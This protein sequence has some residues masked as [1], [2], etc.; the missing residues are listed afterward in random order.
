MGVTNALG[1]MS[2][3]SYV[4]TLKQSPVASQ[5]LGDN[6]NDANTLLTLN[7]PDTR[8]KI[9]DGFTASLT[10]VKAPTAVKDKLKEDF[11]TRQDKYS[12]KIVNA[13]S[14]S[15][16]HIFLVS[17]S[18]MVVALILSTMITERELRSASPDETPGE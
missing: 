18:I 3:D 10:N 13:F 9:S 1:D 15:I 5:V 8:D 11:K 14:T 7:L 17:G 4:Q 6:V 2:K 16:H 12:D